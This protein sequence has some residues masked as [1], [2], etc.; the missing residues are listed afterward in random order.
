MTTLLTPT[1]NPG[2]LPLLPRPSSISGFGLFYA[3]GFS[4]LT[5][6]DII[7]D[8]KT[9]L[10][11]IPGDKYLDEV[12]SW[13][14]EWRPAKKDV[15]GKGKTP[16]PEDVEKELKKCTGCKVVR[17]CSRECQKHAWSDHHKLE[18]PR[19]AALYPRVLPASVRACV[20]LLLL[21][22][23]LPKALWEFGILKLDDH[24]RDFESEGGE[25]WG[26]INLMAKGAHGYSGTELSERE[27]RGL[28]CMILT[29]TFAITP[30]TS[31]VQIGLSFD[32]LLAKINHSC[33]PNARIDITGKEAAVTAVTDVNVGD[34]VT[35]SYVDTEMNVE[36]R[37][38]ELR[39]TWFFEC[40]CEKCKVEL[41]GGKW[42]DGML[43]DIKKSERDVPAGNKSEEVR[44]FVVEEM[45]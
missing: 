23:R 36:A 10:L 8:L 11:S 28:Y 13:C 35:V 26:M 12:C 16:D 33:C 45:D 2:S 14:M 25:R 34:E 44:G 3:P 15:Y 21:K 20:R 7:L 24:V 6:E 19:Y 39:E 41:G 4:P 22:E 27:V 32:P 29:N 38:K 17:Y 5:R 42:K 31:D 43:E 30:P 9:P 37:R 18:C 40:K 1:T